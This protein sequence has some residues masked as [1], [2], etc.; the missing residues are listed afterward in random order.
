MPEH[1]LLGADVI[2][3]LGS[4]C[5]VVAFCMRQ[6][7]PLRVTAILGN[8]VFIAYAADAGIWPVLLMNLTLLPL[9]VVRLAQSLGRPAAPRKP[10]RP[11][12]AVEHA[13]APARPGGVIEVRRSQQC[14]APLV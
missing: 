1:T 2:G 6:M 4:I 9:N 14:F 12:A 8:I 13:P 7:V 10:A 5:V 11:A 3:Y